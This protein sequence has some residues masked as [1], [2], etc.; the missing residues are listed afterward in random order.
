MASMPHTRSRPPKTVEDY[1]ALPDDVRAELIGGEL[2]VTPAPSPAH[3]G[4]VLQLARHLAT[5]ADQTGAGRV[6]MAPI[7]THR[8]V[9]A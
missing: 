2:Y 3:Q 7:E 6:L 4:V 9:S 8:L 1:L 5:Y